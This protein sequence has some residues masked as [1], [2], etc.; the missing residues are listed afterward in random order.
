MASGGR[1]R[2]SL[3]TQVLIGLILGLLAGVV[4]GDLMAPLQDVGK[5]FIL[6][7]QMTVLPYISLSLIT[8]LGA[9]TY[10]QVKDLILKAGAILLLSWGLALLTILVMP[11]AFPVWE[12][13]SFFSTSLIEKPEE[14]NFL[15]LFI[16]ANP[17]YAYAN[18]LVPAVV[19]FSLAVGLA[20]IG[21]EQKQGLLT[22]LT[23]LNRAVT[24]VT[25]FV[26]GLMPYGVFAIVASAAGTLGLEDLAKLQVYLLTFVALALLLS[27]WVLPALITSLTSLTY[28][29]VMGHTHDVLITA[30]ATGSAL[31]VLPL[32][33]ERSKALLREGALNTAE[34]EATV[35]VIVPAFTSFPKIGTLL[36]MSFVLFAGWFAGSP[37]ALAHY[38]TFV[39]TGLVSFFGS[40][41]VAIPL[42]LDLMRIPVDL[43]QLYLAITVV[44]SR[45]SVLLTTMNN[46]VL[47]LVGACAV[48]GLLTVRWGRLLRNAILTVVIGA[49]ILGGARTF[50]TFALDNE[51]RKDE[52]IAS[53]QLVRTKVPATVHH[54]PPPAPAATPLQSGIERIQARG[55][56]RVGYLPDNLPFAYF[57][58]TD[59]LVGFDIEMAHTLA[60]DLGVQLEFV[61]I[62]RDRMAEQV[63]AGYCDIIMSGV[64][65]TPERALV[66][67]FSAPY[68]E[69]TVAF[70]VK[71]HRRDEFSSREAVRR[72]KAPRIGV[73]N[74]PYYIDKVHRYVPQAELVIL[75][76]V[77]EFF[78]Q[79]GDELDAI[80]YSAEA[81]SAWSLRYPAFTVAIPQPDVLTG[82]AAYPLARGD[83]ELAAFLNIWIELKKQ[84]KTIAALYDYWILGKNA[85][86][87]RP[88]WSV[89]RNILHWVD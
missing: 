75:K 84:D 8:G 32:I 3:S 69:Q 20:L 33:I 50:F 12:S 57:N 62:E 81:G 7:L 58:A 26:A 51:Y 65:V 28:R 35:E 18:N 31:V 5:A 6:L 72:L 34:T 73:P 17:F 67:G 60:R 78:E 37:V 80:V 64:A 29:Q 83:Q 16:P 2:L 43:F 70:V 66:M 86:P 25:N 49:A 41:N 61:P 85:V 68:L 40:V 52:I 38:P 47:T 14:I 87:Q 56:L 27:L 46:L 77:T 21:L 23:I 82:P 42:L 76:S 24:T 39:F 71:D 13:A 79:R 11:L 30:F 10:R 63:N 59:E 45:F 88:R 54:T 19:L 22:P 89:V 9:L 36:P 55:V 4:F 1:R 15:T 74:L 48:T 44:I 53:M